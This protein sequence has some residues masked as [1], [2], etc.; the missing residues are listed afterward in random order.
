MKKILEIII[1]LIMIFAHF[2][3][4]HHLKMLVCKCTYLQ[5]DI[6]ISVQSFWS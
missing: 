5:T 6:Y 1:F 4:F 2:N 3:K